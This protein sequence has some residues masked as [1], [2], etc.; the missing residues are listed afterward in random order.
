MADLT[1]MLFRELRYAIRSLSHSKAYAIVGILCLGLG[2]GINAT[3]FSIIDGVLLKPYPYEDPDRLVVLETWRDRDDARDRVSI[4]DLRDW[5]AA[6]R[7]FTTVAGLVEGSLTV[8]DG[9]GEPERYNGARVSWDLFRMLGI[10]P[11]L[12]RDF[13][14]SDDQPNAAGVAVISH[15]LWA[16]RYRSDPQVIGRGVTINGTPHTIVG[17]MPPNFAFPENQRLWVTVQPA[18]FQEP[19]DRRYV[20]TL[21]RLRAGVTTVQA[22]TDLNTIAGRLAKDYPLSNDGWRPRIR[23]LHDVFLPDDVPLVLGLMMAGVT[24]V[25]FIAW[26]NVANL[27]LA[28]ATARRHELAMRVALG[29]GRAR[30]V[31]QLL[32]E[33]VVLALASV[34]LGM[35]FAM[36]GVRLI[37]LQVPS[38]NIPYYVQFAIDG[39]T[40]AYAIAVALITSL[41]FGLVPALQITR[42]E[43]QEN[44]K[45]GA[46]G[47]TSRGA[48]VRNTLVV[49]QV[50]LALVALVGALLFVRSFRNLDRFQVGFDTTSQLTMRVF[51]SGE[52]YTP[53]GAKTRRVEDIVR[54][55]EALPGVQSA[56]A[57][58]LVPIQGGGGDAT[59][60]IEG[61]AATERRDVSFIAVTPHFLSTLGLRVTDGRDLADSDANRAVTVVNK[62]MATHVWPGQNPIGRRFRLVTPAGW[63]EWIT[64]I[65]VAPDIHLYGIDPNNSQVPA[66]AFAP[67]AYGEFPSTGLTIRA[68]GEPGAMTP[69]VRVAIRESDPNLPIYAVR[70]L[71]AQRRNEFW[72]FGLYG[73]IFGTIGVIGVVLASI[74]VYGVLAY[75]VSQRTREIGVRVTLGAGRRE[76]LRL[77][78]GQGLVL[79]LTGVVI[80]LVLAASGTPLTRRLLYGVSPFD[81]FSF[82]AVSLLLFAVAVLA[83][84]LPA[85]RA[86]NVDPVVALRQE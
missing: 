72:Q 63:P 46:R 28:R 77:I 49:S 73:W 55:I 76:V 70:T 8:I 47:S 59:I 79:T 16:T 71:E 5:R 11:I 15:V 31:L 9:V 66:I 83:S 19:R 86:V 29:A 64:V 1:P 33:G 61:P 37:W 36:A 38:D 4:P 21:A 13:L 80:G 30:I 3:I 69:A 53:K 32:T 14:E 23:T 35:V 24:L 52:P 82:V 65:G 27:L 10:R 22:L 78:V 60:E 12:G 75:S 50:S 51:M 45:E 6:N 85:R 18:L 25:L 56:F 42:R 26:S 41:A 67:Y 48:I 7:S 84:Y 44:L 81:P 17:V 34:P 20:F 40:L 2:I 68:A 74:G 62:A 58:N 54:R 57:S 39:R 43:L